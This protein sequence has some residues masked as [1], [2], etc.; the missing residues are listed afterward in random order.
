MASTP[1]PAYLLHQV[2]GRFR[3]S[4]PSE[5]GKTVYFSRLQQELITLHGVRRLR[6][7]ALT[8]TVLAEGED[9]DVSAFGAEAAERGL[10]LLQKPEKHPSSAHLPLLT[11][12]RRLDS[13]LR[14]LTGGE[15]DLA[16]AMFLALLG[17]GVWELVRGNFRT[18]PWYTAFWYAF[19]VLTKS[20]ADRES[21]A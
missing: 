13:E 1:P 6:A 12:V 4:V 5:R 19:G 15:I 7:N 16:V 18:P 20:L 10:L 9:L 8:G 2:P 14:R 17:F 21:S 11:P 3:I